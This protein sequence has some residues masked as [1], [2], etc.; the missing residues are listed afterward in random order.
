MF[1]VTHLLFLQIL[2][3]RRALSENILQLFNIS[4]ASVIKEPLTPETEF[5]NSNKTLSRKELFLFT[6]FWCQLATGPQ[7][8]PE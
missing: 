3:E 4:L 6:V 7:D 8:V 5:R 2:Y 1:D